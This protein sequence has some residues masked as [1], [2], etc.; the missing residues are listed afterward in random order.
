MLIKCYVKTCCIIER[1]EGSCNGKK[2]ESHV[3]NTA[4]G[5]FCLKIHVC[6]GNYANQMFGFSFRHVKCDKEEK[7]VTKDPRLI[8]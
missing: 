2:K 6:E 7:M 5:I 3:L 1:R 8:T 4:C